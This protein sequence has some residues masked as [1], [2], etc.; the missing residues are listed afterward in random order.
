VIEKEEYVWAEES[1]P[2]IAGPRR[3]AACTFPWYAM[4][5]CADGRVTPCPQDFWAK[6]AMGNVKSATLAEVWNG[7]A[8]RD[9]RRRFRSDLDSLP[10]CRKC[11]RLQRKTVGGVPL[12][13]L[14]TFLVDQFVGYNRRLRRFVGTSER[15]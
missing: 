1:A 3:C 11:D 7:E 13:Y 14:A 5:I 4:V 2:E 12:Q 6:M 10:L 9:L 8:Y 15:N